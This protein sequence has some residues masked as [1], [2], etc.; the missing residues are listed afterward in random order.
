VVWN[1]FATEEFSVDPVIWCYPVIGCAAYRGYFAESAAEKAAQRLR[2]AARDVRVDGVAAYSTL[3]WFDDPL[4]STFINWPAESLA[5]LLFHELA[6][7]R[8]FAQGDTAFNES[9]A[10]F[11]EVAALEQWLRAGADAAQLS[12]WQAR[13]AMAERFARFMLNWRQAF[14]ALYDVPHADFARRLL[15]SELLNLARTCYLAHRDALGGG[16]RDEEFEGDFNNADFVP[17]MAYR[18]W[19]P[20][21]GFLFRSVGSDWK[22]FHAAAEDLAHLDA[23]PRREALEALQERALAEQAGDGAKDT[24]QC[25]ALTVYPASAQ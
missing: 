18:E 19:V 6:H 2:L 24:I 20:A 21:F 11:V 8:L 10:S 5:G 1:V 22:R 25:P 15:K 7:G 12:A 14:E 3:G 9:Y 13:R 23:T 16:R 17:W 4:L